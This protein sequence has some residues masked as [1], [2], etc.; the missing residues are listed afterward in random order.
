M[1]YDSMFTFANQFALTGWL[2]LLFYP[3]FP[4][5]AQVSCGLLI[6]V[7]LAIA[8]TG[9]IMANWGSG[10]G[11]FGSLSGVMTLFTQPAA[12]L[13]GWIH[14]LAYDLF[15]GAWIARTAMKEKIHYLF[16]LPCLPL[17]LMF[18]PAGYLLFNAIRAGRTGFKIEPSS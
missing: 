16:V 4:K 1:N 9:L 5:F 7:L 8:Y 18:G 12:V 6:P 3:K 17:A 11:D 15:V 14:Y 2:I 10:E 13:A